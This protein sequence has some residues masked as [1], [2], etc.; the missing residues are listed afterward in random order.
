[1]ND[2]YEATK[3]QNS[4]IDY[5]ALGA[6]NFD[7]N[8][9]WENLCILFLFLS[10]LPFLAIIISFPCHMCVCVLCVDAIQ[11]WILFDSWSSNWCRFCER[12]YVCGRVIVQLVAHEFF[13]LIANKD[14]D[15][16]YNVDVSSLNVVPLARKWISRL[17]RTL[18]ISGWNRTARTH[19]Q[20]IHFIVVFSMCV[21]CYSVRYK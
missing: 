19:T 1:M 20:A 13:H 12:M 18:R 15:D 16:D 2:A 3:Q 14:D 9:K 4:Q 7:L 6:H 8:L 17:L 5:C 10:L 21:G 11:N